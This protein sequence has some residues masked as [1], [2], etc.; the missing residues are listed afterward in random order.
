MEQTKSLKGLSKSF[1]NY[2]TGLKNPTEEEL[3]F[4][5][6]VHNAVKRREENRHAVLKKKKLEAIN[7]EKT[8]KKQNADFQALRGNIDP[9]EIMEQ[10]AKKKKKKKKK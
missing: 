3:K 9:L 6:F 7:V 10:Q 8:K 2:K 1:V 4:H 5:D